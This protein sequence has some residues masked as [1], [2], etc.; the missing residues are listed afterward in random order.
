MVAHG[1]QADF[2]HAMAYGVPVQALPVAAGFQ[3]A[4]GT[5]PTKCKGWKGPPDQLQR[6]SRIFDVASLGPKTRGPL[7]GTSQML[8]KRFTRHRHRHGCGIMETAI[9]AVGRQ[10]GLG[11]CWCWLGEFMGGL[12]AR[13]Y[14]Q[15]P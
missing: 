13:R 12:Q 6:R 11:F 2:V 4:H 1:M 8:R 5:N 9:Y 7:D 15:S 14:W 10:M 3:P